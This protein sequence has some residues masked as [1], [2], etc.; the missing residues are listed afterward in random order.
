VRRAFIELAVGIF[1]E[2]RW[3]HVYGIRRPARFFGF[4]WFGNSNAPHA[5]QFIY[6]ACLPGFAVN[7]SEPAWEKERHVMVFGALSLAILTVFVFCTPG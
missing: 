7:A 3:H 2:L 4:L 5:R 6:L 1:Y